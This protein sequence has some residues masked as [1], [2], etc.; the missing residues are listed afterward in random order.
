MLFGEGEASVDG[1]FENTG[2]SLDKL[3]LLGAPLQQPR[4]RTEGSGFIVSGHAV[5]D[6][7]L[8]VATYRQDQLNLTRL[9]RRRHYFALSS[10]M[11][12]GTN[13]YMGIT[14]LSDA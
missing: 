12:A 8:H 7:D 3:N 11:E 5:F 6:S 4:P 9:P 1:D 2:D 10:R 14:A 13:R